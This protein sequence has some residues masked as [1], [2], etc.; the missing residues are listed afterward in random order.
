MVA[1]R[2]QADVIFNPLM[3]PQTLSQLRLCR[4]T[5]GV[6]SFVLQAV[7]EDE[8][9]VQLLLPHVQAAIVEVWMQNSVRI[10]M[11]LSIFLSA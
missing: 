1:L 9:A 5:D 3:N 11:G 7:K 6:L 2:P 8:R 10:R 4:P